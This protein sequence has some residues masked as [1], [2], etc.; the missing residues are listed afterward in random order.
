MFYEDKETELAYGAGV[1]FNL[2]NLGLRAEY[3]KFDTD[4]VGDLDVIS[5]GATYT[6]AFGPR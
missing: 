5:I 4:V 1:Q 2:G 3:E 6:F